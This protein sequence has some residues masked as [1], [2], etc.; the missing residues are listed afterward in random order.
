MWRVGLAHGV[1]GHDDGPG[2][3]GVQ[4]RWCGLNVR[5]MGPEMIINVGS[6]RYLSAVAWVRRFAQ[7]ARL[8][9]TC[10]AI[11]LSFVLPELRPAFSKISQSI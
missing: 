1:I 6:P 9:V 8:E 10:I 11:Y 3:R 2:R 4:K 5:H 7:P